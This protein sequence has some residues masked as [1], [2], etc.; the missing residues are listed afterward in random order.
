MVLV[1]LVTQL[2][3]GEQHPGMFA[4][5]TQLLPSP[6]IAHSYHVRISAVS[7]LPC[8][9]S[10]LIHLPICATES[11]GHCSLEDSLFLDIEPCVINHHHGILTSRSPGGRLSLLPASLEDW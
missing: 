11:G 9:N 2:V 1:S 6:P 8:T 7:S 5:D 3:T 4:T 10:E